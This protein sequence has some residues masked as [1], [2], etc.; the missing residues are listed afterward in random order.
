VTDSGGVWY[1]RER[2]EG[3]VIGI[4]ASKIDAYVSRGQC[5]DCKS[6]FF[7]GENPL[8]M[9]FLWRSLIFLNA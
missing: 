2:E 9:K 8:R 6:V 4:L 1:P 7:G 3:H 5:E